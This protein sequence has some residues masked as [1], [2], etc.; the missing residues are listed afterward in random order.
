M[1]N[2]MHVMESRIFR[3]QSCVASVAVASSPIVVIPNLDS[4]VRVLARS[5]TALPNINIWME[6]IGL[7]YD[8]PHITASRRPYP[9][10]HRVECK[11]QSSS[12]T[13]ATIMAHSRFANFVGVSLRRVTSFEAHLMSERPEENRAI[14]LPEG[15]IDSSAGTAITTPSP[16]LIL[17]SVPIV[18]NYSKPR[19]IKDH[20]CHANGLTQRTHETAQDFLPLIYTVKGGCCNELS[21]G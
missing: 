16:R 8:Y 11:E 14:A 13:F 17:G 19:L 15:L 3:Q 18:E 12:Q 2:I 10:T 21:T 20:L 1:C 4:I 7:R 6:V 9:N 5:P